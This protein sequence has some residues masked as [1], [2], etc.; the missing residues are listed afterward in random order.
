MG[1]RRSESHIQKINNFH[2]PVIK[3]GATHTEKKSINCGLIGRE[4]DGGQKVCITDNCH[5]RLLWIL[6]RLPFISNSCSQSFSAKTDQTKLRSFV[7]SV[8]PFLT[9]LHLFF[10]LIFSLP[11][12]A[13]GKIFSTLS[14]PQIS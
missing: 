2:C 1:S 13:P 10:I 6:P 5:C 4:G 9:S 3:D 8:L 7:S 11:L 14:L 12:L